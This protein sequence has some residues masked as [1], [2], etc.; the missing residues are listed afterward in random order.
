MHFLKKYFKLFAQ[1]KGSLQGHIQKC[2]EYKDFYRRTIEIPQCTRI[3]KGN[4]CPK[5]HNGYLNVSISNF[6]ISLLQNLRNP[7]EGYARFRKFW[8]FFTEQVFTLPL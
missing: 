5:I 1:F 4:Y 3:F 8:L 7:K 6:W 2:R